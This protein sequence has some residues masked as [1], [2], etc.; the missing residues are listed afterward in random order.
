MTETGNIQLVDHDRSAARAPAPAHR[1]PVAHAFSGRAGLSSLARAGLAI[2]DPVLRG[3]ASGKLRDEHFNAQVAATLAT[4]APRT[5]RADVV[6]AIVALQVLYDY[7]DVLSE[8][9]MIDPERDGRRL[10][11]TLIDAVSVG[12]DGT[13]KSF[14]LPQNND[15][16]YLERLSRTVMLAMGRLPSAPAV[17]EV[18]RG[19]AERCGEAQILHHEASRSGSP[20]GISDL[21]DWATPRAVGTGLGWQELLAGSTA[22]VLAIHALIV[23]AADRGTTSKDAAELDRTYLSIGA[24]SML[25]SLVDREEDIATGQLSYV[26]LYDG[27]EAMA[28]G[29]ANVARDGIARARGLP[30]GAHNVMTLVGVVGYYASAPAAND[31]ADTRADARLAQGKAGEPRAPS[32]GAPCIAPPTAG[33]TAHGT[34][35]SSPMATAVGRMPAACQ[36]PTVTTPVLTRSRPGCATPL[37]L[38]SRS[39]PC[40]RSLQRTGVAQRRRSTG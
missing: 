30:N 21:R 24:L 22:S 8:Q 29:L 39:S 5:H 35:R 20:L 40:T 18:A 13:R 11:A 4:L 14:E 9:P 6:E 25:D 38:G 23:A 1:A 27:P 3:L 34:S 31:D 10:F 37:S 2:G 32:R 17:A 19:A 33:P 36:S 28:S 7:V 16:G 26:D 12:H 15:G